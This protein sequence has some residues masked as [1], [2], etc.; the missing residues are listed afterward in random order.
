MSY[1]SIIKH[2]KGVLQT[3]KALVCGLAVVGL[4]VNSGC[5]EKPTSTA[6]QWAT[7]IQER[8]CTDHTECLENLALAEHAI[9]KQANNTNGGDLSMQE[10]EVRANMNFVYDAYNRVHNLKG[11]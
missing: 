6:Q 10:L 1:D 11:E 5:S 4:A 8:G 3:G 2:Y 9:R 7:F